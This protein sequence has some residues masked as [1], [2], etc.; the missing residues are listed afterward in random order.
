MNR[1]LVQAKAVVEASSLLDTLQQAVASVQAGTVKAGITAL[2]G[3]YKT[4][5]QGWDQWK[6]IWVDGQV[7]EGPVDCPIN[8][9]FHLAVQWTITKEG[10]VP[11]SCDC[12]VQKPSG[13]Q[14]YAS[15]DPNERSVADDG[16]SGSF[17]FVWELAQAGTYVAT[18]SIYG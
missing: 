4:P 10:P 15:E 7:M 3:I 1:A 9:E 6:L 18:T 11:I 2:W 16:L 14:F 5:D 17:Q 13:S 8:S 12:L